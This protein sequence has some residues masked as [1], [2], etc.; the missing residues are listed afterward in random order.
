MRPYAGKAVIMMLLVLVV[1]G[2]SLIP[3][4]L[5][6]LLI[7]YV[8]APGPGLPAMPTPLTPSNSSA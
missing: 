2:L 1:I 7:D 4:K 3:Q 5:V 8:L 6:Q